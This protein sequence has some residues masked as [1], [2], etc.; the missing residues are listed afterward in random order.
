MSPAASTAR[1]DLASTL[2]RTSRSIPA[3]PIAESNAAIVV[4]M[5]VISSAASNGTGISPPAYL[6]KPGIVATAIRKMIVSPTSRMRQRDL[7]RRLLPLG[8]FDERDHPVE[9]AV[10]R[11]LSHPHPDPV[12]D[13]TRAGG[14]R[15]AVAASLADDRRGFAGDRRLVHRCDALDHFAVGGDQVAGLDENN[16]AGAQL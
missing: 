10:P 4:G 14:H 12:G 13:D 9:K 2:K 11:L 6:A 5:S 3:M 16:V 1:P 15:R 7:V 8:A